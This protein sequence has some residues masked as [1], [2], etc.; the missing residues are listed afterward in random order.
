MLE[1]ILELYPN[2]HFGS[3]EYFAL[4][5]LVY[6]LLAF[7]IIILAIRYRNQA[8]KTIGSRHPF[9][10][11]TLKLCLVI[12][13]AV[14]PLSI[15]ALAEPYLPKKTVQSKKGSIDIICMVD[16][17]ISMWSK[18]VAPSRLGVAVREIE[19]AQAR[20]DIKEG[21]RVALILFGKT[22]LKKLRLS[23]DLNR[24][25]D[26]ISRIAQ[27]KTLIG[28]EHPF[29][30]DI[31]RALTDVYQF[32][33]S[34]DRRAAYLKQYG[35][36]P[37]LDMDWKKFKWQPSQSSN[38]I[39]LFFGDGDYRFDEHGEDEKKKL[40]DGLVEFKR[41]G[42]KIY[43]VGIGSR[44]GAKLVDILKDYKKGVDYSEKDEM[45]LI[46]EG[47]TKLDV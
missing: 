37:P 20:S 28:D 21:D 34:Q 47:M 36:E 16:D 9:M 15:I 27:P 35:N 33:D 42:L 30:S 1:K 7:W 32:L 24:F 18:D 2:L 43:S 13:I 25:T 26:E 10:G 6:F 19:N 40:N 11:R 8:K 31:P 44:T 39:V 38:R 4:F 5:Q 3:P 46:E 45:D 22:S 29:G 23:V 41:R 17:S 12:I 14:I